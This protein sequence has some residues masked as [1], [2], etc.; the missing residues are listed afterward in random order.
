[1]FNDSMILGVE[2]EGLGQKGKIFWGGRGTFGG[3]GLRIVH[4]RSPFP[5]T[6]SL[7]VTEDGEGTSRSWSDLT[8]CFPP[9]GLHF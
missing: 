6:L 7:L 4:R 1:M 5:G 9:K 3:Q 2:F 8:V